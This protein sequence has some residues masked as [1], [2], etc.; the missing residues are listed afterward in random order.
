MWYDTV[1]EPIS[2]NA[3]LNSVLGL[4]NDTLRAVFYIPVFRFFMMA[5]VFLSVFSL[6]AALL[7]Q[8]RQGKL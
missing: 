1:P 7:R 2:L 6:V 3:W 8:G 4:F 5:A